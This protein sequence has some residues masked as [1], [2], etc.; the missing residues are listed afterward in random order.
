MTRVPTCLNLH[1]AGFTELR[2]AS[3]RRHEWFTVFLMARP[4]VAAVV[5]VAILLGVGLVAVLLSTSLSTFPGPAI[6]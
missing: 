1:Q 5:V 3:V 2:P 4:S 6:K